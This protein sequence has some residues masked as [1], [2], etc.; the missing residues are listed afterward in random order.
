MINLNGKNI[1]ITG[2][3]RGIGAGIAKELSALG[4]RVAISY[5]SQEEAAQKVLSL[6]PGEGHRAFRLKL[7]EPEQ[8]AEAIRQVVEE[9]GQVDGLV[10]NA[11]MVKDQLALR[12][13][14]ADFSSVIESNLIGSF[15]VTKEV[16][17]P[18]MKA[19]SGS[20][21]FITSVIGQ[22]GNAGQSNYAASKAGLEAMSKSFAL[23][24]GSRGVRFNC[25]A[26]GF[27]GTD[28]TDALS[29]EQKTSILEK[30]PLNRLGTVEDISG[31]VSFL[32]SDRSRYITGQT[33]SVNG[34][35]RM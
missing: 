28:M 18:M 11:G 35:M 14:V 7:N 25:V 8:A 22:T 33:L 10:N 5:S 30:V 34:G 21:V 17:R 27:I 32:L 3:S 23:E 1:I 31:C 2:G 19:K 4:A 6:L 12:M 20:V 24:F 9:F 13:S 16:L 29:D 26:P 15:A